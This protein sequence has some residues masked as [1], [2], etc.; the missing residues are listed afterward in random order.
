[1]LSIEVC[2]CVCVCGIGGA[3]MSAGHTGVAG[4]DG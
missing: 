4:N 2:V 1:M 3:V